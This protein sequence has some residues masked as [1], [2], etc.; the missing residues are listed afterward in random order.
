MVTLPLEQMGKTTETV[1][2]KNKN[3]PMEKA[4][5]EN[6]R[7]QVKQERNRWALPLCKEPLDM[8]FF[9]LPGL[10]DLKPTFFVLEQLV[11]RLAYLL[12]QLCLHNIT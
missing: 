8:R 5:D 11:A 9:F 7:N 6:D 2:Y 12:I 4:K 10:Q 1:P 3:M